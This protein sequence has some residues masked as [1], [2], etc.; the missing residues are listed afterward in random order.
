MDDDLLA[1]DSQLVG[2]VADEDAAVVVPALGGGGFPHADGA[3]DGVAVVGARCQHLPFPR[4]QSEGSLLAAVS[5]EH[6]LQLAQTGGV[7]VLGGD[8]EDP[9]LLAPVDAAT[10]GAQGAAG[11]G[12]GGGEHVVR[13]D[14]VA[15][16]ADHVAEKLFAVAGA[17]QRRLALALQGDVAADAPGAHPF[18]FLGGQWQAGCDDAGGAAV[19]AAHP[20]LHVV[21]GMVAGEGQRRVLLGIDDEVPGTAPH[22]VARRIAEGTLRRYVGEGAVGTDLPCEIAGDVDQV[23]EALARFDEGG[24]QVVFEGAVAQ[25]HQ[26]RRPAVHRR[27]RRLGQ[28]VAGIAG[29]RQRRGGHGA[30]LAGPQNEVPEIGRVT[31]FQQRRDVGGLGVG[32][33]QRAVGAYEEGSAGVF[34]DQSLTGSGVIGEPS[35]LAVAGHVVPRRAPASSPLCHLGNMRPCTCLSNLRM[36]VSGLPNR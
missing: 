18:T 20:H 4:G 24:T 29:Q 1:G 35:R 14:F 19:G 34:G 36:S 32:D 30:P 10:G 27:H 8:R 12:G 31:A 11:G 25:Q 3:V 15:D 7:S 9:A 6:V 16:G 5:P 23:L 28:Y 22:Q 33:D 2:D 17:G 26:E 13:L 21:E